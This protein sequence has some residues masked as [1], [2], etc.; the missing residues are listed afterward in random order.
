MLYDNALLVRAYT[1]AWQLTAAPRYQQVVFETVGYLLS[2]PLRV[3]EG[4]WASAEDADSEGHE[5]RFYTWSRAEIDA[6]AGP[7]VAEW[8]G[9]TA[10]GN[11]EGTNILW[12]PG[13]GDLGRPDHIE[14]G[15]RRLFDRRQRRTRPGLDAKVLTEWNAMAVAA[16]AYAG[17]AFGQPAWVDA[18]ATTARRA[19]VALLAP[20]LGLPRHRAPGPAPGLRGRLRLVGGGLHPPGRGHR[21]AILDERRP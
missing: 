4:A 17:T 1:H 16:L 2:P 6:V 14:D 15:R 13:L 9:A 7:E 12:R 21:P 10:V 18:A 3:P 19:V 11:W 8:Y 5:G 20:T